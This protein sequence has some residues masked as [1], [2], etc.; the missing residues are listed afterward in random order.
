MSSPLS[1][2]Q[3]AV[4]QPPRWRRVILLAVVAVLGLAAAAWAINW[5]AYRFSHSISKDAFI[6]SHLINVSPQV[7][8]DIVAV[9]V[10][11]QELVKKGQPLVRIDPSTYQREVD[12]AEAKRN[13]AEAALQKAEADLA[14]LTQE[15]PKRITI[16]AMRLKIAE[17][18][19]NKAVDALE[20][21]SRDTDQAVTAAMRA[22]EGARATF[23]LAEEDFNRYQALY[24]DGSVSERKYQE[25]TK[26]HKNAKADL[27]IAEAKLAQAEANKKK[28]SIAGQQLRAARH[29]VDE[30][31]AAVELA[32]LGDLQIDTVKRLVAERGKQVAEARRAL[33]LAQ[34][35]LQYT[36]VMAPYD[37]VIAKKWRH[38]GDY[39]H[40]G[41][42]IFSVYNPAL[43][44]VTV[45]LEET[46]L[47]GVNSGNY[48]NLKVDAFSKPF[49]GRVLWVGS[50]TG[51]NFSLIPRDI[52]SGEFTY[53][54]QRVPTRILFEP[55][56]RRPQLKPGLSVTVAIEHGPGDAA[57]A[58]EANRK[59]AE[60]EGVRERK[61]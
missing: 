37:G 21:V 8:G 25:A 30:A 14:L 6:E 27:Q 41:D 42:P 36:D 9:Y 32:K 28:A 59:L 24:K 4:Q 17:E 61:P 31:K 5:L 48:A 19:E 33:E 40:K 49:R 56:D 16:S 50:A 34:V 47:E 29:A 60:I 46:L 7:A 53:V 15:V 51:A 23:V 39:A 52:S 12:L 3:Q 20:M 54:V 44:W 10:Q 1:P 58:T 38:L 57:W 55:D 11:E 18:D 43:L 2:P 45:N 35:N 13:T 26:I 22:V